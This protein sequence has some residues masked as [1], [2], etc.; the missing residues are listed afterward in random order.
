MSPITWNDVQPALRRAGYTPPS[1]TTAGAV[2][3]LNETLISTGES[4]REFPLASVTKLLTTWATL[5][6]VDRGMLSLDAPIRIPN[7][8]ALVT[9]RQL[10]AHAA[11]VP[12]EAGGPVRT[13]GAIRQYS[14]Y[15]MEIAAGQ[16]EEATGV[17]FGEW[18]GDRVVAPLGMSGTLLRGSPAWGGYSTISDLQRF[19]REVLRPTLVSAELSAEAFRPQFP[20]LAGRVPGY[21]TFTPCPWGL[22][23][24]IRGAK[25]HWLAPPMSEATCGHFGVSGSYLWVDHARGVG[26]AFLGE[27]PFGQWHQENWGRLN[28]AIIEVVAHLS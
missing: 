15:G 28:G 9:L 5:V 23:F 3:T 20:E 18:L 27:E 19:G 1:F 8:S 24:E 16:V 10:L 6:A 21:H 26:A 14:N 2:F 17:S 13:P 11:G 25:D 12:R 4:H 7:A 22:G